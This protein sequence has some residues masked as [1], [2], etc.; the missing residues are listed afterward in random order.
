MPHRFA[1]KQTRVDNDLAVTTSL[2][3]DQ[4]DSSGR[5]VQLGRGNVA[6]IVREVVR[7]HATLTS[8][9]RWQCL[10]RNSREGIYKKELSSTFLREEEGENRFWPP[11]CVLPSASIIPSS[12]QPLGSRRDRTVPASPQ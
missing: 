8:R 12:F 9:R 10:R 1:L 11:F 5:A 3:C 4:V 6:D 7:R 2:C